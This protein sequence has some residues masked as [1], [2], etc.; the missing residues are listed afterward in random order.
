MQREP[1][2]RLAWRGEE[3]LRLVPSLLEHADEIEITLPASFNHALFCALRPDAPA[4]ALEQ[5]DVDGRPE[6]LA[7]F[8]KVKGL[9]AVARL[10]KALEDAQASVR[11]VSPP[12]LLI[13]LPSAARQA[14]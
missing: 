5:L 6:M 13:T 12:A 4:G 8:A 2:L 1:I 14:E 9:E 7:A 11:V 10:G 3:T